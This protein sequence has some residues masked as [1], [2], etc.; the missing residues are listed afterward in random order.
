MG[1][2]TVQEHDHALV[3]ELAHPPV[4]SWSDDFVADLDAALAR[5][6]GGPHRAVIIA[7]GGKHFSAG[8]DLDRF[9]RV[10]D[11]PSAADFLHDVC[12]VMERVAALP[13]PTIAAIKGAALGGGLELALSCDVRVATATSRLGLPETSLGV[14]PGASGTQR[15]ARLVGPGRAKAMMFS[16][17]PVTGEEAHRIGLVETLTQDDDPLPTALDLAHRIAA[18]SPRAVRNVKRSVDEG[19]GLELGTALR[20]ERDLWLDLIPQGDLHEGVA[21]FVERRTPQFPDVTTTTD[22][23]H[24]RRTP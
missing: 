3:L 13:M 8:G 22:P 17:E 16:A 11:L 15:L 6:E 21:A 18:N 23:T 19:L 7:S 2:V 1:R 9:H 20:L 10:T 4:N 12:A 24:H 14:L 5:I